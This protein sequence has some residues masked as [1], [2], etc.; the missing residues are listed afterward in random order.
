MT[1]TTD[2][3]TALPDRIGRQIVLPEGHG[4][5]TGLFDAYRW[6]RDNMPLAKAVVEG[7]DPVWLV[8]KHADIREVETQP[9]IFSACGGPDH[10]GEHNSILQNQAGDAFT[11]QLL[12]GSLRILDS[13]TYLDPPEHTDARNIC[14]HWFK[15]PALQK[16]EDQIRELARESIEQL[17]ELSERGEIDLLDD[18]ALGFP[19][20][21]M[22]TL[23]GVPREDE[24]KMLALTQ[25]FF[26][27]ADPDHQRGDVEALSPEAMAQQWANTIS[28]FYSYFDTFVEDRRAH[29]RDDLATVVACAE[30]PDGQ[31]WPKPYLYG[32]YTAIFTAGHDTTSATLAGTLK[33]LAEHPEVLAR[34][35]TDLSLV[36]GLV[37]E[38]LR[39]VAPVK[40]FMRRAEADYT[41]RGQAI[42]TG[43]RLMPLFQSACRD[44]E[45][46]DR[47]DEFDI[48]RKPNNHLAF[49][50]GPHTCIGMHLAKQ[51]LQVMFEELLPRLTSIE[52]LGPGTVTQT[53]F[54]GGLKHLPAKITLS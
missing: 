25:E 44:E 38:G 32:W 51:E 2:E 13:L 33:L 16:Y 31:Y 17:K 22:M 28:D 47:P 19:L 26:G 9:E 30:Q 3:S 45:L 1:S 42:K 46:F 48:D 43:D 53:N 50:F 23:V 7:Y 41:L 37:Q 6:L 27:T 14:Y 10:P 52:I 8:S 35:K 54:V 34:V 20:H 29:P 11:K 21:V 36:P 49:G 39:H 18:W 15:R 24:P 4:D 12:G 5:L 40:H